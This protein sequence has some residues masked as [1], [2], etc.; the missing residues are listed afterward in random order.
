MITLNFLDMRTSE[1]AI[2]MPAVMIHGEVKVALKFTAMQKST[3][4]LWST[5]VLIFTAMPK[6]TEM[7]KFTATVPKSTATLKFAIIRTLRAPYPPATNDTVPSVRKFLKR[8]ESRFL[9]VFLFFPE[10]VILDRAAHFKTF[11]VTF[12][13]QPQRQISKGISRM[14]RPVVFRAGHKITAHGIP[15]LLVLTQSL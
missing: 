4:R 9:P 13:F 5:T 8:G 6:S 12:F 2:L 14:A 7:L 3:E 10:R 1:R 15:F 11:G